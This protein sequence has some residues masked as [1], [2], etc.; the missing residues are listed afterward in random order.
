MGKFSLIS[1]PGTLVLMGLNGP[2]TVEG[3]LGLRSQVSSCE[4]AP[5]RN[6]RMQLT[7]PFLTPPSSWLSSPSDRLSAPAPSEPALRKSRRDSPEQ[8][9]GPL[10]AWKS[11]M[12]RPQKIS[13]S[14]EPDY[15]VIVG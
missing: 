13:T 11:S 5:T 14:R 3:A 8:V 7:S 6:S 9:R 12:L 4:G 10:F 1:T 2:R 15:R